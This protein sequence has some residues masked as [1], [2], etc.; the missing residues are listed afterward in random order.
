VFAQATVCKLCRVEKQQQE[1]PDVKI[2][3]AEERRQ[4]IWN[5]ER[6]IVFFYHVECSSLIS[7]NCFV[8]LIDPLNNSHQPI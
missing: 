7:T 2:T 5:D 3:R 8:L 6:S 1:M 4:T